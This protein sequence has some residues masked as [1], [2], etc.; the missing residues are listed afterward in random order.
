MNNKDDYLWS[1]P[2]CESY[3]MI[4][5]SPWIVY[6]II[7]MSIMSHIKVSFHHPYVS[8]Y[9]FILKTCDNFVI[10][11]SLQLGFDLS[12]D[13]ILLVIVAKNNTCILRPI[14]LYN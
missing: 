11:Q 14:E 12:S 9:Y 5:V 3:T 6:K 2:F 4:T 8:S 13:F 1:R 10:Y 7:L